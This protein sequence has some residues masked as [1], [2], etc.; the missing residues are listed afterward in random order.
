[1]PSTTLKRRRTEEQL[2]NRAP[3]KVKKFKKQKAYHSST[4][5]EEDDSQDFT[6]VNVQDSESEK[7]EINS[8]KNKS[9]AKSSSGSEEGASGSEMDKDAELTDPTGVSEGE[10][11]NIEDSESDNSTSAPGRKMKKR[12][13]P[14]AFA[15]SIEKILSSKLSTSKRADPVLSRS[16]DAALANKELA[17]AKLEAKARHKLREEK[18]QA[19][20]KGRVTDV[21][22]LQS[23]DTST[24][25]ITEK[26]KKLRKIAQRG[27]IKLF[28]AFRAAQVKGEQAAR[29]ARKQGVVGLDKKQEKVT[30]MSKKGFLDLIAGGGKKTD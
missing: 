7:E 23:T 30:E 10:D 25:E 11:E 9:A 21:L 29:E 28:N 15:T 4:E 12:N 24:A 13:D 8:K 5:D 20:D 18:R 26:E 27:V 19:L 17:D 16:K 3:K 2:R 1:M 6:A 14:Q 22:G